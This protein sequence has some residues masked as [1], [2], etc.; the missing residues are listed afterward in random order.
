MVNYVNLCEVTMLDV[1]FMVNNVKQCL[2]I[3]SDVKLRL[4]T[5]NDV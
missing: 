5:S 3:F 2:V 1:L 4:M